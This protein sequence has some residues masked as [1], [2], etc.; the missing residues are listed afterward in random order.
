MTTLEQEVGELKARLDRLEKVLQ[1]LREKHA[2]GDA[3]DERG[4]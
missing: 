4:E 3:A 1:A 2:T